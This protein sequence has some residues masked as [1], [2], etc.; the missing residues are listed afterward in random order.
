MYGSAKVFLLSDFTFKGAKGGPSTRF[1]PSSLA[2]AAM[3]D[4]TWRFQKNNDN[5]QAITYAKDTQSTN[6]CFVAA[7]I[8]V[9]RRALR[10][11]VAKD[12]P[13]AVYA[14]HIQRKGKWIVD[15]TLYVTDTEINRVLREVAK[16]AHE[17]T[18]PKDLQKYTSHSLRVGACVLLHVSGKSPDF[19]KFRLRWRSDSFRMYLRNLSALARQHM[20]AIQS[21]QVPTDNDKDSLSDEESSV[22]EL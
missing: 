13:V 11:K 14:T 6:D 15:K 18:D 1:S 21:A 8:V 4:I 22:Q 20:E 5:G 17:I 9:I 10:L 16:A 19:I 12:K 3:V 7:A 2:R